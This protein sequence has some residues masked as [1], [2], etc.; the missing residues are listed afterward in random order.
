MPCKL[1]ES[2]N[3]AHSI[4]HL[5][6]A[7]LL[8]FAFTHFVESKVLSLNLIHRLLTYNSIHIQSYFYSHYEES[9]LPQLSKGGVI[10]ENCVQAEFVF[11][12]PVIKKFTHS[13]KSARHGQ[14]NEK[15][16][17]KQLWLLQNVFFHPHRSSW[18]FLS[19]CLES[20]CKHLSFHYELQ[21]LPS[22]VTFSL[23][24]LGNTSQS[25]QSSEIHT[26]T[27]SQMTELQVATVRW[28]KILFSVCSVYCKLLLENIWV[29]KHNYIFTLYTVLSLTFCYLM[30]DTNGGK[31]SNS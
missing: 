9:N 5:H 23:L 14:R 27:H 13:P 6:T 11:N 3:M 12:T 10:T 24:Q 15:W 8:Q 18:H 16:W 25:N 4:I 26:Y 22:L 2:V 21:A 19:T 17:Y 31:L 7:K 1:T 20:L 29:F 28:L 30:Y